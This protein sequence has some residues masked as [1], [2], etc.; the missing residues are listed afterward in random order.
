MSEKRVRQMRE[1]LEVFPHPIVT[2]MFARDLLAAHDYWRG[3]AEQFEGAYEKAF[4]RA[5]RLEAAVRW[6]LDDFMFWAVVPKEW[7][8]DYRAAF[9]ARAGLDE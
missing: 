9:R 7:G 2:P 4:T 5:E 1:Y 8:G 6:W 3:R